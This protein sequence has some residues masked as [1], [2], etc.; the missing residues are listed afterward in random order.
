MERL[1]RRSLIFVIILSMLSSYVYA[2]SDITNETRINNAT[3]ALDGKMPVT[4][5]VRK[6]RRNRWYL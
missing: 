4:N 3:K 1:I 5:L 6:Y 2:V